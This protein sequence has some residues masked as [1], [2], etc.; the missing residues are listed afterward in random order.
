LSPYVFFYICWPLGGRLCTVSCCKLE[1]LG[2]KM[3][4]IHKMGSEN[5]CLLLSTPSILSAAPIQ[6]TLKLSPDTPLPIWQVLLK[7]DQFQ[8]NFGDP[9]SMQL[10]SE[11]RERLVLNRIIK[12]DSKH[13]SGFKLISRC[14]YIT[15]VFMT[16]ILQVLLRI[17]PYRKQH[18][19]YPYIN[20]LK[21]QKP[22]LLFRSPLVY[23]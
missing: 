13:S 11:L 15:S 8:W 23:I 6:V 19:C 18:H 7:K 21:R 12:A 22:I 16:G 2:T 10:L 20:T 17:Q 5:S 14:I 1:E 4:Q 3:T 9:R